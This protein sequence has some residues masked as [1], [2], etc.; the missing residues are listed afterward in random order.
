MDPWPSLLTA[1]TNYMINAADAD[2]TIQQRVYH[3]SRVAREIEK[4]PDRIT[5][6]DLGTWLASKSWKPNTRRAY[7][8]SLR[9]FYRWAMEQGMITGSPAH[10]LP[11]VKVPRARPLPMPEDPFKEALATADAR[12][13]LAIRLG[14]HC[15]MRRGEIAAGHTDQ[16][17]EDL[18]GWSLHVVGKGGHERMVP[19]PDDLAADLLALS[20]GWFFPSPHGGHLTKAYLGKIIARHLE[21]HTTHALRHRALSIAYA[22]TKDLRAVQEFAGHMKPETTAIYTLV[23]DDDVRAAMN[24]AAA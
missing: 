22:T 20:P 12:L 3:L 4:P 7:R 13:S 17:V 5:A 6:D 23:P 11:P 8:G 18:T 21:T 16:L 1:W 9:A 10:K 14:G 15:A 2:G 19:L 24:A